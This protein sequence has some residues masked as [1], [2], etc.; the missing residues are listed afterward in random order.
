MHGVEGFKTSVDQL[1]RNA[2]REIQATQRKATKG[3]QRKKKQRKQIIKWQGKVL[4][5]HADDI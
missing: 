3:K 2:K 5:E 1:T 4:I